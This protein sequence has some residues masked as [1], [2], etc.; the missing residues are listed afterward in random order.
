VSSPGSVTAIVRGKPTGALLVGNDGTPLGFT[1]DAIFYVG[2]I[3]KQFVA[4]CIAFLERSCRA[5][6]RGASASRSVT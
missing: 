2:S 6:R 3:A 1:A 4:A 5:F